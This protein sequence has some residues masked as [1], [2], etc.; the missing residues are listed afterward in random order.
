MKKEEAERLIKDTFENSFD[1]SKFRRFI[2]NLLNE[3]N[4]SKAFEYH[5]S[6]ISDAYENHIRQYKRL[7]QYTDPEGNVLD[8]LTVKLKKESSLDR[9]RG[10]Q[11]NFIASYFKSRGDNKDNALVAFYHDDLDE[12][13]FSYVKRDYRLE[14]TD[15]GKVKVREDL[16]PARRY[17]FLVGETEPSHSAQ[18]QLVPILQDD[19]NNPALSRIEQAFGIEKVT[20]EFFEKYRN[21][22]IKLKEEIDRIAEKDGKI[23]EEFGAKGIS[24]ENFAKKLLGQIVFLYFLQKKG[25]M[26][27]EKDEKGNYRKWGTGPKD[28]LRRLFDKDYVPYKNFFNDVL[29]PL[30]YQALAIDRGEVS[31]FT[32]LNCKIPFLNGGLFEPIGGYNW[33]ETDILIENETFKEIFKIFDLYNFTVREDEPLEKEVAVDPEMLGKVFE[34]LLEIKDRKSKGAYYTPREIVHYM[35]QE[36]LIAYLDTTLNTGSE[37]I[38]KPNPVQQKLLGKPDP[39]QLGLTAPG[40]KPAVPRNDIEEFI[41]KGELTVQNDMR[42]MSEGKETKTYSLKLPESVKNNAKR[43]DE[44]L[45]SIKICDPAIGSGAFPVGMMQEIVKA[46]EVIT[47]HIRIEDY[48]LKIEDLKSIKDADRTPYNFKRH[49]IQ[50]SL[51]GVDIDPSAVDIAK[52]RLWLSLVVDED[53]YE[54]IKPLPNLEYKIVCGN[55]LLGVEKNLLNHKLFA[56]LETIKPQYFEETNPRK[57]NALKK[58]ID[59][60]IKQITNNDEHFDFEVY[61]SEVFHEKSGFDV[62]I[63]NP[64]Y[65]RQEQIKEYKPLFKD[66]YKCYTGAADIYV[67]FFERGLSLLRKRGVLTFITSNKYMRAGYGEKLREFIS[68]Y[69]T[70]KELIDFG[71]AP[72]F[73][74]TSYPSIILLQKEKPQNGHVKALSWQREMPVAEFEQAVHAN[75]FLIAQKEFTADGWRIESRSVLRLLEK[76]RKAGQPLGQYVNG[77]FYR[78]I[79]TGLNEAFVVDRATR[80]RLIAEHTS[81]AEMLKPFLRGRDVKRWRAEP[82]DLWLIF[83]RRGVDIK[84]YPAILEHLSKFKKS[85]TPGIPGGR[86]PG[87]YEWYEIQDNIAYWKEFEQPKIV[88]PNICKRNEFAWDDK[89]FYTNQKA[90]IIPGASK[91]LLAI[92]NSQVVF[93]LFGQL[94]AKLQHDYFEPSSIFMKD[95]PIPKS[96]DTIS[97][98]LLVNQILTATQKNPNA[99]VSDLEREIDRMVYELYGLTEEEVRVVEGG[100]VGEN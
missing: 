84:K 34:N 48:R 8:V 16:S 58:Q 26:G 65:V 22:Y 78:G 25:W 33:E 70:I 14:Q 86:K 77:R 21:L 72:V 69:A 10:M 28:F 1:E 92:L 3:I 91:Y 100:I 49:C 44:S 71:D 75:N 7:G 62:V 43:I 82:K 20:K 23:R 85:L 54:K 46:R 50:E 30:F 53:D 67:Y 13:R 81:S 9:A 64:P 17:S 51:Y 36:S 39:E 56:E 83:T 5:G 60:L 99:D 59:S 68:A 87:S 57:K 32:Q 29:E 66:I 41:R 45:A 4:E 31:E 27:V 80:D 6:Y 93:W 40:Y 37:P 63:G 90:F 97:I 2:K 35:C 94:L 19:K 24:T 47:A 79:L 42:V 12:W 88:Y 15:S 61:F 52:L 73:E 95:F 11:R 98:D 96:S 89:H 38:V 76:L 74:A 55:S 18:Q